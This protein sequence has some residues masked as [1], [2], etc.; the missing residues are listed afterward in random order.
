MANDCYFRFTA[1]YYDGFG[2]FRKSVSGSP[3]PEPRDISLKIFK[4]RHKPEVNLSFQ[5]LSFGQLIAHD[6]SRAVQ[7]Q[8]DCCSPVNAGK[9]ECAPISVRPDDPFY[10]QFNKTCIDFQR[11]ELC[12]LGPIENREQKNGATA[13]IDAS[14]IYGVNE[15]KVN[16]LR[17]LDGT[18]RLKFTD[19]SNFHLLPTGK[20]PEDIFCPKKQ[21]SECFIAGDPR[22]NQHASLTSMQT[23]WMREHNRLAKELKTMNPLW[24]EEKLFQEARK[25]LIAEFQCIT[26]QDFLPILLTPRIMEE[27]DI[28]IKKGSKGTLFYPLA[29]IAVWH[30]FA[31][32]AFRLHSMV[33]SD[34]GSLNLRFKD[35]FSNPDLIRKGHTSDLIKGSQHVPTEKFDRYMVKDLTDYLYK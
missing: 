27:F 5:F 2:G 11:S 6:V 30:D 7:P 22:V 24:E 21:E 25:I 34:I 29:V 15:N 17:A 8:T 19:S 18:G 20:D 16:Q 23:V 14:Y 28:T 13:A 4:D 10:S 3:L 12:T 31:H 26:Y 1:P 33:P 32:A 35:T 9:K